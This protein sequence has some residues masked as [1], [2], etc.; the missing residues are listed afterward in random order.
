MDPL[1]PICKRLDPL[2]PSRRLDAARR[3]LRYTAQAMADNVFL[4]LDREIETFAQSLWPVLDAAPAWSA[5]WPI[6]RPA[7]YRSDRAAGVP[8]L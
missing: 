3:A 7:A 5:D 2:S 1:G 6:E 8:G 4:E